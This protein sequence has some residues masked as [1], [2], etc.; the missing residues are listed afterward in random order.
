M[1]HNYSQRMTIA[2]EE[3]GVKCHKIFTLPT[4]K[5]DKVA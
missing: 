3:E 2:G 5:D 1:L 4:G